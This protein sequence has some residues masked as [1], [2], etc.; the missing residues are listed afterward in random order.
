[1]HCPKDLSR[2]ALR[3]TERYSGY[4]CEE[5]RGVWLTMR[6]F[7]AIDYAHNLSYEEF[8]RALGAAPKVFTSLPCPSGCGTL[9]QANWLEEPLCWCP[10]C[11]GVWFDH[12]AIRALRK[13][14]LY[15]EAADPTGA[16]A[17]VVGA[18]MGAQI[19]TAILLLTC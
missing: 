15:T 9:V 16:A 8:A 10:S 5:C 18:D 7:H 13:R 14:V 1:M 17:Y 4:V 6:H 11:Q 3:E 2:L 12:S 19:L